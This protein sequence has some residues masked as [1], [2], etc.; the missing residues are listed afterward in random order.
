[1]FSIWMK[2]SEDSGEYV[3]DCIEE[4]AVYPRLEQ[5]RLDGNEYRAEKRDGGFATVLGV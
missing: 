3:E 4:S 5:L 1:M 2:V